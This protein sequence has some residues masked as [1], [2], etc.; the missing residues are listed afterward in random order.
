MFYILRCV[1][2][3]FCGKSDQFRIIIMKTEL[4]WR[5]QSFDQYIQLVKRAMIY[6]AVCGIDTEAEYKT[7]NKDKESK[8]R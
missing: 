8:S 1:T 6:I 3:F 7:K 5:Y 4:F 2:A